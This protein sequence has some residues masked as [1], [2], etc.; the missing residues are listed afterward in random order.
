MGRSADKRPPAPSH[1]TLRLL[2][3]PANR[4]G[5]IPPPVLKPWWGSDNS[6]KEF[7]VKKREQ[8]QMNEREKGEFDRWL[9]GGQDGGVEG[10]AKKLNKSLDY[11]RDRLKGY[12]TT[13]G[14][15]KWVP[16]G[17]SNSKISSGVKPAQR[18]SSSINSTLPDGQLNNS[19]MMT[20][21]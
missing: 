14:M 13:N 7:A 16:A 9:R 15:H 12:E 1:E 8:V 2:S 11:C 17:T 21:V 20:N 19:F 10:V 3:R 6:Q 4:Y 5:K 18:L